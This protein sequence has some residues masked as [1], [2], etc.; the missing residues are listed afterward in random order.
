MTAAIL[1]GLALL[2]ALTALMSYG[3]IRKTRCGPTRRR[4][5]GNNGR[6]HGEQ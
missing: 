1:Y 3:P 6:A 5:S 4:N 2:I